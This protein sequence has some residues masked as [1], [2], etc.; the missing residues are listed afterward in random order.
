MTIAVLVRA[1]SEIVYHLAYQFM[2]TIRSLLLEGYHQR[3][4]MVATCI[5]FNRI[6]IYSKVNYPSF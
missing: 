4:F 2:F 5:V 3:Y 6:V 1:M